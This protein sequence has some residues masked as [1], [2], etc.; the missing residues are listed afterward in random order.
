MLSFMDAVNICLKQKLFVI[1]GRAQR[2]E[3]WWFILA[4]FIILF[5]LAIIVGMISQSLQFIVS[6]VALVLYIPVAI[7]RLHDRDMKAWWLLLS[8]IPF[9]GSIALLVIFALPGTPGPNRFGP[10]PLAQ[11]NNN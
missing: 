3:F 8:L 9:V 2:S 5:I 1:D 11:A 10:D 6:I 4:Q 7:R